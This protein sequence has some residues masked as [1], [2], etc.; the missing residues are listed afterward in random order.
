MGRWAYSN[1][2]RGFSFLQASC[3]QRCEKMKK[4]WNSRNWGSKKQGMA[5]VLL[6]PLVQKECQLCGK[7]RWEMRRTDGDCREA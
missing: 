2:G 1:T 5:P 7:M 3:R 4:G 6:A